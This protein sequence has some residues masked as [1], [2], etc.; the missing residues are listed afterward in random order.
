M[1]QRTRTERDSLGEIEVPAERLWGAQ[2]ERSLE[3]FD[4]GGPAFVWGRPIIR[5]LGVLK[6]SAA[7]A[8]AELGE[9]DPELARWIERA[10]DEVIAGERDEEFPLVVFQTGSGTQSNMNANE[11]IANLASELA[12][13]RRGEKA[14]VHPNDHVNRGQSSN[15]TFPT[16]M[17]IAVALELTERLYPAVTELR[18][19]LAAKAK[20]Y[21]EV[22]KVGRTHLQDATPIT[23]GQEIS[24]WVAQLDAA[25]AG[26]RAAEDGVRQL[27]IGGTAVG[28]G[29]NA[30]PD[31]GRT[32]AAEISTETGLEFRQADNLF[33]ALA[34]HDGLVAVSSALRTLGGACMK[35]AND[36]RWLA[37]GPRN[38]I[39]ELLI[40]VNEPGSSI[41][42]G[43]VNPT[44]CEALT[45]VAT[46]VFGNDATVGFAGSQGNFELNVYKPVMVHAVLESVRLLADG[47]RS[48]T[49][50]CATG[51]EPNTER[52]EAN[53]ES[54]LMLVTALN[55]HIGYD[56]AA[57]I[58]KRA[59]AEGTTLR[60]AAL[61][62]G[63]DGEDFDRWVDPTAMTTNRRDSQ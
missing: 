34:A 44:Q 17:H 20:A 60:E 59:H 6:K 23:L 53:L 19:V 30:H 5:A 9:L 27:A 42:P 3:N 35:L 14:P 57:K 36:V 63:V 40:P 24:G 46:R 56:S 21:A 32:A 31:F 50:H 18:D 45:M 25:L 47:C 4:I 52:I 58:A 62:E 11:V 39:G 8:N 28:T 37:S 22:V 54:N 13:G 26:V 7:R 41:M 61:A 38:G 16:A 55:P 49:V 15:D 12:G 2:T 33:A 1:S 43:K 29:L 10:A 51:I 48:F